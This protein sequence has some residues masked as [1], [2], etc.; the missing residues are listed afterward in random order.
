MPLPYATRQSLRSEALLT[1]GDERTVISGDLICP[2]FVLRLEDELVLVAEKRLL[3]R[4]LPTLCSF[5]DVSRTGE[6]SYGWTAGDGAAAAASAAA[7]A[8]DAVMRE[9]AARLLS[10]CDRTMASSALLRLF[11]YA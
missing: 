4:F 6:R 5:D 7:A 10:W 3:L 9:R 11:V 8:A 1:L 2:E